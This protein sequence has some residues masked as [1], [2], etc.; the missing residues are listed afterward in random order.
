[1]FALPAAILASG[2]A[3]EV[4]RRDF[5]VT[6]NLV[7]RVP[8][9]SRLTA[10]EISE[11]AELLRL[12]TAMPGE[13]VIRKGDKEDSLFFILVGQVEVGLDSGPVVLERGEY[14]GEL[15]IL[16]KKPRMVTVTA[17]SSCQF[18]VL[19]AED[20]NLLLAQHPDLHEEVMRV[21][22]QRIEGEGIA[23]EKV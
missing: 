9:F 12:Q 18:L 16:Y 8:L 1:M 19:D 4:K 15:G 10:I 6:W 7:A 22:A 21:A 14:F 13:T 20:F 23:G 3:Q 11:I 5:T 2:F 17:K